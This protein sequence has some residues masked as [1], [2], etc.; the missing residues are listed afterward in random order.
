MAKYNE[1]QKQWT[2]DYI[3][4]NLDEIKF[5]VPKGKKEE[6]KKLAE[7]RGVSLTKLIVDLLEKELQNN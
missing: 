7:K 4:N 6:Y 5:R 1:N 2:M 3:K